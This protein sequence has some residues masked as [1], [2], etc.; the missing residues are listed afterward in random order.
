MHYI[1][2]KHCWRSEAWQ[3][4]VLTLMQADS[5]MLGPTVSVCYRCCISSDWSVRWSESNRHDDEDF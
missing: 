4:S 5:D 2:C 1:L 3:G